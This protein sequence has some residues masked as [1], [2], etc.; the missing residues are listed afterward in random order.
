LVLIDYI[1]DQVK[2]ALPQS[3]EGLLSQIGGM[4]A[5][6]S[7]VD[8]LGK[9]V[10]ELARAITD[11]QITQLQAISTVLSTYGKPQ[12]SVN[13]D[14]LKAL[15]EDIA[16][17]LADV[18]AADDVD[19]DVRTFLIEHLTDMLT[20]VVDFRITGAKP[21]ERVIHETLGDYVAHGAEKDPTRGF[22][23][24]F[25]SAINHGA[26][27][28]ALVAGS[29]SIFSHLV[30]GL[31]SSGPPII[32]QIRAPEPPSPPALPPGSPSK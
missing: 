7:N 6:L 15:R 1:E 14:Q 30:P 10:S 26:A 24:A 20:A 11:A 17:L 25:W 2:D 22:S 3:S 27:I 9:P 12:T 28:V 13:D 29:L 5:T 16:S 31:A 19:S 4:R 21:L 23:D 32:V 18:K 8:F